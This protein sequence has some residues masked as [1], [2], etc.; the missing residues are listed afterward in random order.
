VFP[1]HVDFR[2]YTLDDEDFMGPNYLACRED[3]AAHRQA[4]GGRA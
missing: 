3:L 1:D 4:F 2:P